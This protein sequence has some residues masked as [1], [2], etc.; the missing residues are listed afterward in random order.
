MFTSL[1]M[2]PISGQH[3]LY[4]GVAVIVYFVR[5]LSVKVGIDNLITIGGWVTF[6]GTPYTRWINSSLPLAGD[7]DGTRLWDYKHPTSN[8]ISIRFPGRDSD[9]SSCDGNVPADPSTTALLTAEAERGHKQW[10]RGKV[11]N[12][13][14]NH[15]QKWRINSVH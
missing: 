13:G 12:C 15:H 11:N 1:S 8:S 5:Y 7:E 2:Q 4:P 6:W 10:V 3:V 14:E 9:A